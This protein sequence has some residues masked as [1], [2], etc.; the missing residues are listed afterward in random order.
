MSEPVLDNFEIPSETGN[1]KYFIAYFGPQ[2]EYY[3]TRYREFQSGKKF[4]FNIGSFL[5]GLFWLLYRKL[6]LYFFIV[7][8]LVFGSSFIE[9]VV[10]ELLQV[11]ARTQQMIEVSINI[12]WWVAFGFGG[13]Y[14][15]LTQAEKNV[16]HILSTTRDEGERLALLDAKGGTSNSPYYVLGV[17]ILFLALLWF[18]QPV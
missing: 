5:A 7:F 1:E 11:Q 2:N 4:S 14:L 8:F 9:D 17:V 3:I 6:Y 10:Y 15:Y 18:N 16:N 13:N 12:V